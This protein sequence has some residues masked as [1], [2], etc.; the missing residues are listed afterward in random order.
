MKYEE[1]LTLIPSHSMEDLP[2]EAEEDEACGLLNAFAVPWHPALLTLCASAP[3]WHRSDEPPDDF[4]RRLI[5][6]PAITEDWLPHEW[7]DE[8]RERGATV[9][10]GIKDRAE[11]LDAA[12]VAA[13]VACPDNESHGLDPDIVADF[14][15]L[16]TCRLMTELLTCHMH[17]YTGMDEELLE[18]ESMAGARAAVD[19]DPETARKHLLNAFECLTE[20]RERLYPVRCYLLDVCLLMDDLFDEHFDRLLES[21]TPVN[22]LIKSDDLKTAA[23]A[24]PDQIAQIKSRLED[25]TLN[26]VGG[27]RFESAAPVIPLESMLWDFEQGLRIHRDLFAQTPRTWGRR[28]FGFS[29][30]APQ[31][32]KLHGYHSALHVALDDGL[33]PDTEHSRTRWEGCDGSVVSALTRIPLPGDS[34]SSFLRF[35]VRMAEAMEQDMIASITFAR[36]PEVKSPWLEDFQRAHSYS[37]TLGEFVTLDEF[38]ESTDDHSEQNAWAAHEYLTP[39]LLQ[40]VAR[41]ESDAISRFGRHYRRRMQFDAAR[42]LLRTGRVLL[43]QPV[44]QPDDEP[45]ESTIEAAGPDADSA[46]TTKAE[47]AV[48]EL[49][50]DA[51]LKLT[52][53]ISPAAGDQA[54]QLLMNPLSFART[55]SIESD[56]PVSDPETRCL[57]NVS[58]PANGFA[59]ISEAEIAARQTK[60][61]GPPLYEDGV[62]RNESFE[63]HLNMETGGIGRVKG[64]GRR[65]NRISQQLAM[66]FPREQTVVDDNGVEDKTFYSTMRCD[67]VDVLKATTGIVRVRTKGKL[68]DP[69]NKTP[70]V[71]FTQTVTVRRGQPTID[72]QIEFDEPVRMP[73]GDPWSNYFACR[74]AWNDPAASITRSVYGQAQSIR[75][76]RFESPHYIEI[77]TTEERTTVVTHGLAFHRKTSQRMIDCILIVSGESSRSFDFTIALDQRM[78]MQVALDAMVPVEVLPGIAGPPRSGETGWFFHVDAPNVQLT[79]ILELMPVPCDAAEEAIAESE[80]PPVPETGFALR[81]LETEGRRCRVT[82][83]CFRVPVWVRQRDFSGNTIGH[84]AIEGNSVIVEMTRYEIADIELRFDQSS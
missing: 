31:V 48:A 58:V 59:W 8:A 53:L 9:I 50:A 77:A 46:D 39:F 40:S 62:L 15:A 55:C 83:R 13:N 47:E 63:V 67:Q 71:G 80:S 75:G 10:S 19:G 76:E 6:V 3:R 28:R 34:A 22:L 73:A 81:L 61:G 60:I 20:A 26:L 30:L 17:H 27:E 16:G 18:R 56:G 64:H 82:L 78:P 54:G 1:I 52:R 33:Y 84:P 51:T 41:Q 68:I 36:W 72:L 24:H 69:A 7:V 5:F 4:D 44:V 74:F 43:S 11:L 2:T 25:A 14:L 32:L 42:F 49:A 37:P 45:A 35:P 70:I 66:R 29:S 65:P 57:A 12:L 79:S 23:E 38:I 21:K